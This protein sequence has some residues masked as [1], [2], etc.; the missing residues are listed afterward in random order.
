MQKIAL[1]TVYHGSLPWYFPFFIKSCTTNPTIDFIIFS[2]ATYAGILPSNVQIVPFTLQ[3]F[4]ALASQKLGFDV[5][6]IKPYKLCDFKPAFGF[7]FASYLQKYAFWGITDIDVVYGR[8]R[9]FMTEEVLE[10]HDIICVRNDYITAC[11]MLFKNSE[12]INTLFKKSADYEMVFTSNHYYGFDETNFEQET[13]TNKYDIFALDCQIETM[14][15]VI[16]KEEDK[17]NLKAHFDLFVCDGTPG[18]IKWDNG[19]LSYHNK[20]E[21]LLYHLQ[22]YKN[23]FFAKNSFNGDELPNLFYFDKYNYRFTN[24]IS[25]RLQV[26]ITDFVLPFWWRCRTKAAR[27][28]SLFFKKECNLL[29]AGTYV[30]TLSKYPFFIKKTSNGSCVLQFT[31]DGKEHKLYQLAF[32]KN[33]YFAKGIPFLLHLKVATAANSFNTIAPNGFGT[34]YTK[35]NQ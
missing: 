13:I 33:F 6:V 30:Y 12:Y 14:Q 27:C 4:N 5:A 18:K 23:N 9:E 34:T 32:F 31:E 22:N 8:I 25:K 35:I 19:L 16:L 24:T 10:A 29:E 1:L 15:H 21:I 20:F 26:F 7:L 11:C 3:Q 2:D 17:G 28:F